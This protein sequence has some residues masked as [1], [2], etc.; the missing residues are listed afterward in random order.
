MTMSRNEATSPLRSI[1]E[2]VTSICNW[3]AC[4]EGPGTEFLLIAAMCVAGEAVLI[5]H[6]VAASRS[7]LCNNRVML[8]NEGPVDVG[9]EDQAILLQGGEEPRGFEQSTGRGDGHRLG[10]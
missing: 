4:L 7:T 10:R 9:L 6:R 1:W 8:R 3:R 5:A 2:D